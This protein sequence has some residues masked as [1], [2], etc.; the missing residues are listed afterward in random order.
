VRETALDLPVSGVPGPGEPRFLPGYFDEHPLA[1]AGIA[2]DDRLRPVDP[3]GRPFAEN[4]HA[5]GAIIAGAV[6]WREQSGN[7]I[8]LATGFAAAT[9]VLTEAPVLQEVS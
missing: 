1:R 4:L 2:V 9:A 8:A 7:G 3:A 6:P 5:A